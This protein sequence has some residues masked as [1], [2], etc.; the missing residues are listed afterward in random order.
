MDEIILRIDKSKW[1]QKMKKQEKEERQ[2]NN[3]RQKMC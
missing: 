2:E 1:V 3:K